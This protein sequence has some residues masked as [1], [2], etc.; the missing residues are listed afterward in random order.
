MALLKSDFHP[1]LLV[2]LKVS[3]PKSDFTIVFSVTKNT[4]LKKFEKGNWEL[5]YNCSTL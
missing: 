3:T 1:N 4:Y 5:N 2:I